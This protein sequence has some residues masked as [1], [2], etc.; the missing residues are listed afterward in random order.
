MPD[1]WDD[2]NANPCGFGAGGAEHESE[3][4]LSP[5]TMGEM[6][7]EEDSHAPNGGEILTMVDSPGHPSMSTSQACF[8]ESGNNAKKFVAMC[9]G[10]R[11]KEDT[12]DLAAFDGNCPVHS[13]LDKSSCAP[14]VPILKVEVRRR[15]K[16]CGAT[17][18]TSTMS[19]T[20]LVSW[21]KE[22]RI[23]NCLC[24]AWI[25]REEFKIYSTARTALDEQT[26][27]AA[28]RLL[29]A[30]WNTH[31]PWLRLC[32]AARDDG[33]RQA[34]L[35][36]DDVKTRADLDVGDSAERPETHEEA[37]ARICNDD[38]C[39]LFTEAIPTLH[40]LFN[41]P[42]ELRFSDMPGGAVTAED[43]KMRMGDARA[44]LVHASASVPRFFFC[45]VTNTMCLFCFF[46]PQIVGNWEKSGNGFGQRSERDD[47]FGHF[48]EDHLELEPGD[49]RSNFIRPEDSHRVH[50]L[51]LWH[52]ADMTGVLSN[53][54]NVVSRDVAANGEA[55]A[56]NTQAVQR[57]KRRSEDGKTNEEHA[58]EKKLQDRKLESFRIGVVASLSSISMSQVQD[59]VC[60]EEDKVLSFKLKMLSPTM[61]A[62]EKE[63]CE[64]CVEHA[65]KKIAHFGKE[66]E[67]MKGGAT[68]IIRSCSDG[69]A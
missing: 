59:L 38:T 5:D 8:L 24:E 23:V 55:C 33:S 2:R 57:T 26:D 14:A 18:A 30:N 65:Y 64:Q 56:T 25:R 35:R 69:M 45:N 22:N 27:L 67:T 3:T 12:R 49:N 17:I 11:N 40:A 62:E 68:A 16:L 51:H 42:I 28:A 13:C 54:L 66:V 53:V 37:I 60:R 15:A 44:K 63:L 7:G 21:L 58:R 19:K 6:P 52:L 10:M 39:D 46:F 32:L 1:A 36:K 9:V 34:L 20:A 50:H 43:V 31:K 41:E 4:S 61:T 48:S 47:E 29:N